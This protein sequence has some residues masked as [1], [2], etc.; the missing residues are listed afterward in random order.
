MIKARLLPAIGIAAVSALALAGCSTA[1]DADA[2]GAGEKVTLRVLVNV[3]PNL[4][5]DF[6]NE[7]VAP[8]EAENENIDV[9][10]QDP[11][12]EG[13]AAAIPRLLASGDA[14]DGVQALAPNGKIAHY[15]G[16]LTA[17]ELETPVP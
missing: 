13:V 3:T 6:W 15:L 12:A 17:D 9:V 5:E 4:T 11:G 1:A 8:F 7:L 10:I 14:P 16:D 2:G